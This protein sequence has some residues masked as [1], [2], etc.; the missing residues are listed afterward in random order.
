VQNKN[1]TIKAIK[2]TLHVVIVQAFTKESIVNQI[3]TKQIKSRFYVSVYKR[4]HCKSNWYKTNK[5]TLLRGF[6]ELLILQT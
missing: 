2:Y 3:D 6:P 5:I 4:K 1:T